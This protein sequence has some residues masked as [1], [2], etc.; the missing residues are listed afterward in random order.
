MQATET[1]IQALFE[2]QESDIVALTAEKKLSELPQ[3]AQL[4]SLAEKKQAVSQKLVQVTKILD[5][6]RRKHTSIE[7]ERAILLR[8]QDETQ[9]KIDSASGDFR[10][11]QSL[12]R[13][14]GGIAK[15]LATLE[16][17]L[18]VASEKLAQV[19]AVKAQVDDAIS[20]MDVQALRIR[21]S[22]QKD[23]SGLKAQIEEARA[24]SAQLAGNV[25]PDLLKRYSDAARRCG[26][27]GMARL[28]ENRCSTCRNHIDP[29]KMLQV[30]REAPISNCPSCGRLLV[31]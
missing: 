30:K 18:A 28:A 25:S 6:A 20:A 26:G 12:T 21:D 8:K 23:A 4:Q 16:E 29:N 15:R 19:T 27:I 2:L 10:S 5:A 3:R 9:A 13:D 1:E 24:K 17:E 7:D 22:F 11:V 14:L 31:I